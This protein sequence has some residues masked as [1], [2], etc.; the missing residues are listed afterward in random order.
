MKYELILHPHT[1]VELSLRRICRSEL[2]NV[3]VR[4]AK[5][6]AVTPC[7]GPKLLEADMDHEWAALQHLAGEVRCLCADPDRESRT[8]ARDQIVANTERC[9][10]I[11]R[12]LMAK[13]LGH[14]LGEHI[15]PE[16]LF[17]QLTIRRVRLRD[18]NFTQACDRPGGDESIAVGLYALLLRFLRT[19]ARR[20]AFCPAALQQGGPCFPR[21]S[22]NTS[23]AAGSGCCTSSLR[24]CFHEVFR[25]RT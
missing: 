14:T 19:V 16:G 11:A 17:S 23:L 13:E 1:A 4:P 9:L 25:Q 15:R 24:L 22:R 2:V 18:V 3:W 21:S 6:K 10:G 12:G 8:E 7:V 5:I 20:G